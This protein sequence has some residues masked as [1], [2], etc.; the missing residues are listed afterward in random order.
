MIAEHDR[1]VLMTD[2]LEQGLLAGDIGTVVHA[3]RGGQ[4]YEV[5]FVALDGTTAGIITVQASDVRS[6]GH[7]LA[8]VRPLAVA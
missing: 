3:Y 4:A 8:H 2:R 7:E 6:V 5:E 1:V